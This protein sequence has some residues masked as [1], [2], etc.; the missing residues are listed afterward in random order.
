M[1]RLRSPQLVGGHLYNTKAIGLSANFGHGAALSRVSLASLVDRFDIKVLS[2]FK[3]AQY[4]RGCCG[5]RRH[6]G[7]SG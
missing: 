6:P 7:H 5:R 4:L 3:M 2:T 1:L